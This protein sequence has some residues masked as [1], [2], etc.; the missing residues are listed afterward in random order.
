MGKE[1][2]NK[3][4]HGCPIGSSLCPT[5][6]AKNHIEHS[7]NIMDTFHRPVSFILALQLNVLAFYFLKFG[8][9]ETGSIQTQVRSKS[10][11]SF[12]MINFIL[13]KE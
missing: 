6:V 7:P 8:K 4:G 1:S 13:H 11:H 12:S 2:G 5:F 9:I 10:F 3:L